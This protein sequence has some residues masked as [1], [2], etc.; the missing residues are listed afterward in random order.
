MFRLHSFLAPAML[1]SASILTPCPPTVMRCRVLG[2]K[3][4]RGSKW[5]VLEEGKQYLDMDVYEGNVPEEVHNI[6]ILLHI[7]RVFLVLRISGDA[8]V[9]PSSRL[10]EG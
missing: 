9:F 10:T 8:H 3:V 7:I 6:N 2:E 4:S 1:Q 5:K